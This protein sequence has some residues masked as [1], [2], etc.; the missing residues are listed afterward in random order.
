MFYSPLRYPGGKGKLANWVEAFMRHNKL[1]GGAYFEPYAGGAAVGLQLLLQEHVDHI[2]IND[3]DPVIYS[4][5]WAVLNE[6]ENL[7][8]LIKTTSI[9]LENREIQRNIINNPSGYD[10]LTLGFAAFFLNRTNRSGILKAGVIGGKNQKSKDLID[11]RFNKANLISRIDAIASYRNRITLT[12]ED[13]LSI[14][15]K[16][17]VKGLSSSLT[18]LDPPYFN[19]GS[20][21]YRNFYNPS[22]HVNIRDVMS[23]YETP[24]IITYDNCSQINE[25]YAQFERYNF[26]ITYSTHMSRNKGAEVLIVP[27]T[28]EINSIPNS[29]VA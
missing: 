9:T 25:L 2:F 21:L 11:A 18:Y 29:K 6:S 7:I 19:K 27:D 22:D 5:W 4:F 17:P 28:L 26:S 24:W 14:L 10:K 13:A 3:A 15:N 1:T 23:S 16:N 20:Q 8:E 12:C